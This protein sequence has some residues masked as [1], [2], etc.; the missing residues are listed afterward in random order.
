MKIFLAG[1]TGRVATETLKKLSEKGYDII[2]G[3]RRP[4][5]VVALPQVTP[6]ILDL[7]ASVGGMAE[8]IKGCDAV[9][10]AAGSRGKDLLQ[11]DA[12]GAVKL[13]QAAEKVGIKRFV[14]LS[15]LYSLTPEKWPDSLT[16]YY[17]A[18]YFADN[19]LISQTQL[20][21]TIIQPGALVEEEGT[22]KISVDNQGLS[23]IAISDVGAVLA[24][25]LDKQE[26]IKKIIEIHPGDTLISQVWK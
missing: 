2:A 13:M 15:A 7:H 12:Y 22:G 1:S 16:D 6:V 11:T 10:F 24:E 14:M 5:A 17:I 23:R 8:L 9:I 3:A 20:D 19:H 4:E 21:Y 25:V 26:T 18:K